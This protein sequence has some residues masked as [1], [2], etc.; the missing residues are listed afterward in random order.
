MENENSLDGRMLKGRYFPKTNLEESNTSFCPSHAWRSIM[1]AKDLVQRGVRWRVGN[2]NQ[3]RIYK[4]GWIPA[5]PGFKVRSPRISLHENPKV[6]DI[7]I[8]DLHIWNRDLIFQEFENE[9]DIYIVSIPI[10]G[11]DL[12]DTRIWQFEKDGVYSVRS[13]YHICL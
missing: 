12:E 4:D 8:T 9:E 7:I 5:N 6:E 2:G 3:I 10:S 1:S 13:A 11:G